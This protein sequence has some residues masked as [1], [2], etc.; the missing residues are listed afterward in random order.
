MPKKAV[1]EDDEVSVIVSIARDNVTNQNFVDNI[2]LQ[3]GEE[4]IHS[5]GMRALG[6][7][8]NFGTGCRDTTN[9]STIYALNNNFSRFAN[10]DAFQLTPKIAFIYQGGS[11]L[12]SEKLLNAKSIATSTNM[13]LS[14]VVIY[15]LNTSSINTNLSVYL[16]S[17]YP[18]DD[19]SPSDSSSLATNNNTF[20][21]TMF[22]PYPHTLLGQLNFT[23]STNAQGR[24]PPLYVRLTVEYTPDGSDTSLEPSQKYGVITIVATV[25]IPFLLVLILYMRYVRQYGWNPMRWPARSDQQWERQQPLHHVFGVDHIS[26]T[27]L[28]E[29]KV[30]NR[31]MIDTVLPPELY[32]PKRIKNS[33]CVICLDDLDGGEGADAKAI[34]TVRRLPC[35]H[36]FC[37]SCVDEWLATKSTLCPICKRDCIAS[38]T[39][40]GKEA[41]PS[42]EMIVE[43]NE[44][45]TA[46]SSTPALIIDIGA[47]DEQG[48]ASG[49][50]ATEVTEAKATDSRV[51]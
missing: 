36:G 38:K 14:G 48:G 30:L 19:I 10:N 8:M 45:A 26:L 1:A 51:A 23:H 31:A 29:V 12:W 21:Q 16:G 50:A 49:T 4:N 46:T 37:L 15:D 35:G 7:L 22:F 6:I 20:P 25:L 41:T 44:F 40:T 18:D 24:W 27:H 43:E 5:T 42:L 47:E 2:D 32:N 13:S 33:A 39:K 34:R 3:Y 17:L 11:C 9:A 28:V